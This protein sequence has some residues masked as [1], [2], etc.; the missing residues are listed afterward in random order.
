VEV[1]HLQSSRPADYDRN[2]VNTAR[3]Y[4]AVVGPHAAVDRWTY[5]VPS[6]KKSRLANCFCR[7]VRIAA[8][9]AAAD[10]I[11][12]VIVVPVSGGNA[13]ASLAMI[14]SNVV[15]IGDSQAV[16]PNIILVAGD[17]VKGLTA[18]TSTTTSSESMAAI[19]LTNEFDA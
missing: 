11:A 18:Q 9:G 5:T 14:F 2:P 15:G 4:N 1:G 7:V 8:A 10:D 12:A 6:G 19:A 17:I 16:A 3:I 13:Y